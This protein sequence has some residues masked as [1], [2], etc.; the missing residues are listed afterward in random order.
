MLCKPGRLDLCRL[1][2]V[3][4]VLPRIE[5]DEEIIELLEKVEC[6]THRKTIV[7]CE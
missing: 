1:L 4:G 7:D 3:P 6:E 5:E 2:P